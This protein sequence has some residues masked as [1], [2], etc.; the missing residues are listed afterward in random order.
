M[1]T[2]VVDDD[3][4]NRLIL[5]ENL[6]DYGDVHIAVNG[7][8]AVAA[9]RLA[10]REN[11]NYN[12]ICLDIMMPEMDGHTALNNI[13]DLEEEHGILHGDGATII[14]TTALDDRDNF[15]GA[16]KGKCDYYLVKP[17]DAERLRGFLRQADLIQYPSL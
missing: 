1:K 5:Q 2:L 17:I 12:L 16:F 10:L 7:E 15:R 13:R 3:F 6:K 11:S 14:M 8:E 9:V 4:I